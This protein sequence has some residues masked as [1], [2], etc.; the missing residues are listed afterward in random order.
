MTLLRWLPVFILGACFG[1]GLALLNSPEDVK[2][3]A[4]QP[5][6][7][8]IH[9]PS[10]S[11]SQTLPAKGAVLQPLVQQEKQLERSSPKREATYIALIREAVAKK[12]FSIAFDLLR[13]AEQQLGVSVH[14][15]L[16]LVEI[17]RLHKDFGAARMTLHQV[18]EVDPAVAEQ[19]YPMLRGVVT[20]L[21]TSQ[22]NALTFDEKVQL[23][24]KEII[25]DPGFADYYTLLGR[26]YYTDGN[27]ADAITNLEYALQLDHTQSAILSPLIRAAK[28]RLENPGLIEVPISS[29]GRALNVDVRLNDAR[30]IFHFILDT[31]ASFTA[32]SMDVAKKLGIVIPADR[33]TIQISTANGMIQ[34]PTVILNAITLQGALVEQVPAVVLNE[35]DGFDGLLGLSFLN[36]FNIDINQDEG[37]L[38]LFKKLTDR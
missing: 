4:L 27:Y 26:L 5:E 33:P 25:D 22:D 7:Q 10:Q 11:I 12:E 28:Q 14:R 17:Q 20:A 35:L 37:K 9:T 36:Q 38:L 21:I 6:P 19:V 29:H 24:S 31:G 2:M 8:P 18:L 34:A 32:I 15:L 3:E 16:L 13:D 1:Y 30:Q 23:L